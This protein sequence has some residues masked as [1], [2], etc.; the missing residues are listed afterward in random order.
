MS[1][2]P[3]VAQRIVFRQSLRGALGSTG[4]WVEPMTG[5]VERATTGMA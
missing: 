2:E 5:G 1:S 3:S 4:S